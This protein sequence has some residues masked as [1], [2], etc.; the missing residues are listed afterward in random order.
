VKNVNLGKK[1]EEKKNIFFKK[2]KGYGGCAKIQKGRM[3][4]F[5]ILKIT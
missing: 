4:L 2:L 3:S 1:I 5:I